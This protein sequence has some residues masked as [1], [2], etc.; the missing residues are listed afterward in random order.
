MLQYLRNGGTDAK[1]LFII[2]PIA[3]ISISAS[4]GF[5]RGGVQQPKVRRPALPRAS[6][7]FG[8]PH[9]HPT[10]LTRPTPL[11]Y[12]HLTV[13]EDAKDKAAAELKAAEAA[14]EEKKAAVLSLEKKCEGYNATKGEAEAIAVADS[15]ARKHARSIEGGL[16]QLTGELEALKGSLVDESAQAAHREKLVHEIREMQVRVV[17]GGVVAPCVALCAALTQTRHSQIKKL[18]LTGSIA[19]AC[20]VAVKAAEKDAVA[21]LQ[22]IFDFE[23]SKARSLEENEARNS[24]KRS[25]EFSDK[26]VERITK[27]KEA[28]DKLVRAAACAADEANFGVELTPPHFI[29]HPLI[30][31]SGR[32]VHGRYGS[33]ERRRESVAQGRGGQG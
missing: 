16:K 24:L 31:P 19:A 23:Y 11:Q 7:L 12:L 28:S 21:K 29:P 6:L 1:G 14:L 15:I 32:H 9:T 17:A 4:G 33:P 10:S 22:K 30:L 13:D 3:H 27:L 18:E 25:K 8:L 26:R 5:N 20:K 2:S